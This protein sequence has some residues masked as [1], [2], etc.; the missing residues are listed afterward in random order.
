MEKL[1]KFFFVFYVVLSA[2]AAKTIQEE[3]YMKKNKQLFQ[4]LGIGLA[5]VAGT[6]LILVTILYLVVML[7]VVDNIMVDINIKA[8]REGLH[9][10]Y[11]HSNL[12]DRW[13]ILYARVFGPEMAMKKFPSRKL[14]PL[15]PDLHPWGK[16]SPDE[17]K[18]EMIKMAVKI[19]MPVAAKP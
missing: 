16:L 6:G 15:N 3:L 12:G 9:G 5:V 7:P 18:V 10:P 2:T 19:G 14:D 11:S 4:F 1:D 13:E 8:T 17:L